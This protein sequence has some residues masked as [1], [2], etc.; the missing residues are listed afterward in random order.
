MTRAKRPQDLL[1]NP[2]FLIT[3]VARLYRTTFDARMKGL[4][5]ERS[6]WWLLSFLVYFEGCTQQELAEVMDLTKGGMGKLID[7]LER[8][9]FVLRTAHSGDRRAKRIVLTDRSRPLAAAV[10]AHSEQVVAESLSPLSADEV[11]TLMR[12]LAKLRQGFV[13]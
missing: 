8:E 12:L 13:A 10:D 1:D 3:D 6:E 7:R 2:A 11:S 9:G 4:G 5:L